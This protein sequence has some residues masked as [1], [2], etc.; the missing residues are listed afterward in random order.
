MMSDSDLSLDPSASTA[1]KLDIPEGTFVL[2]YDKLDSKAIIQSVQDDTAGATAVFI[3][4]TRNS[5]QGAVNSSPTVICTTIRVILGPRSGRGALGISSVQQNGCEDDDGRISVH[6]RKSDS[7]RARRTVRASSFPVAPLHGIPP[8]GAGACGGSVDRHRRVFTSSKRSF[9]GLRVP[10]GTG[11]AERSDLEEGSV[12]EWRAT[13]EGESST[14]NL[15][16][17]LVNNYSSGINYCD[18]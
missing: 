12:R 11:Q 16:R 6:S 18:T 14:P 10:F 5:F 13:V 15:G 7:V 4:T 2:T 1:A 8:I 9:R 3:G 17:A